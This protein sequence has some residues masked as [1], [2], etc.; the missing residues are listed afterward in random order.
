VAGDPDRLAATLKAAAAKV[1]DLT[2]TH[3]AAARLVIVAAAA[4]APR[5]TGRLAAGHRPDV[6]RA[7]YTITNVMQ[8]AAP[9]HAARPW[10]T[11]AI[12][13]TT[14]DQTALYRAELETIA[15]TIE[16]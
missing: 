16:S 10:L 11:Q 13:A 7:G 15:D 8:Y 1:A 3:T 5:R 4:K 12:A 9:V 6:A 2:D 14:D